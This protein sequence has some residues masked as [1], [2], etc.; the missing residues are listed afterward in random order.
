VFHNKGTIKKTKPEG[1]LGI[2]YFK[3]VGWRLYLE[4]G[5]P[6]G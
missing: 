1:T 5:M 3:D 6:W 2:F 4:E